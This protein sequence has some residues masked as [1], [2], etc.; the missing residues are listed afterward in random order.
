MQ[1][2]VNEERLVLSVFNDLVCKT[3][4][5]HGLVL[6]IQQLFVDTGFA[7]IYRF[8]STV[9]GYSLAIGQDNFGGT[10]NV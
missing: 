7:G 3:K 10:F 4:R 5:T 9:G 2:A 6:I 8:V 1:T